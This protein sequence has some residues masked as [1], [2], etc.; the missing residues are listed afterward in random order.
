MVCLQHL[1]DV[2]SLH[3]WNHVPQKCVKLGKLE[4][5]LNLIAVSK[6]ERSFVNFSY[7][8]LAYRAI[9]FIVLHDSDFLD[10]LVAQG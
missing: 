7:L 2:L 9:I 6:E 1:E 10:E 4:S 5:I 8:R 3:V